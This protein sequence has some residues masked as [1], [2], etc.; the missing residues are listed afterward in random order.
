[1]SRG[2]S[3]CVPVCLLFAAAA[4]HPRPPAAA[5]ARTAPSAPTVPARPP[6]PP[7]PPAPR[8]RSAPAALSEA[9]LFQRKSLDQLNGEHPL[10]DAFFDYDQNALRDDTRRA[11]Q[12]DAQWLAQWP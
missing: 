5:P 2:R 9:D 1:M 4:C 3:W 8:A 10:G 12:K 7:P 6:S 11:L